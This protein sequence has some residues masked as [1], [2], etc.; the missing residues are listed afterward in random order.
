MTIKY[1]PFHNR[2]HLIKRA[3]E[4]AILWEESRIDAGV[5]EQDGTGEELADTKAEIKAYTKYY[6]ELSGGMKTR[7]ER[8]ND[9]LAQC[10]AIPMSEIREISQ[11]IGEIKP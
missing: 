1:V 2:K 7:R 11:F 10:Q 5:C 4:A 8:L 9:K 6:R 3:L